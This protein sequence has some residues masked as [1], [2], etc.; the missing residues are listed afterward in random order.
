MNGGFTI[1]EVQE[2]LGHSSITTTQ[3]YTHVRPGDLAAK[4]QRRVQT[5]EAREQAAKLAEKIAALPAEAREALAE[6]LRTAEL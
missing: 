2:L 5:A 4:I 3:V 1:R 6:L